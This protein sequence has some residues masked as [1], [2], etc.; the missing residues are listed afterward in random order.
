[1][2]SKFKN[3]TLHAA[4]TATSRLPISCDV[5]VDV[6]SREVTFRDARSNLI[7]DKCKR[8]GFNSRRQ[9][10]SESWSFFQYFDLGTVSGVTPRNRGKSASA[11]TVATDQSTTL[12]TGP[13]ML[14]LITDSSTFSEKCTLAQVLK[15]RIWKGRFSCQLVTCLSSICYLRQS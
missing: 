2:D 14:M 10:R 9:V 12:A 6:A 5:D 8:S 4:C 15:S 7:S 11:S 1:M 3:R 13:P